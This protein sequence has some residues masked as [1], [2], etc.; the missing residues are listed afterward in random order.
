MS[1]SLLFLGTGA[2]LGVPVI[3]CGCTACSL[4]SPMNQRM[5]SSVLV[6]AGEK[7]FLID[8]GPDLRMQALKFGVKQLD[9]IILT[10]THF[11]HIGGFDD[12]RAFY[13]LKKAP[14]PCLLSQ[15]TLEEIKVRY[16][17]LFSR[18]GNSDLLH[19]Q[20]LPEDFGAIEFEGISWKYLSYYQAGMKVTGLRFG[21]CAYV[22][23]IREYTP[24]VLEMLQDVEILI[25]SALRPTPSHVHF[26][27]DEAIAF[28][29]KVNAKQIWLTHIAHEIDADAISAS[30]P[31]DVKLSY[32]GLQIEWK[33]T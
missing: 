32:D 28:G 18:D 6:K 17:Y 21:N 8:A 11:D 10:H 13:F 15:E 30:L 33:N 9:G 2:S 20:L 27:I 29:R 7:Q 14:L 24:H 31:P 25:V 5:R 16:H 22:S 1:N 26:S 23:D 3:G 4:A 12:L 19:F